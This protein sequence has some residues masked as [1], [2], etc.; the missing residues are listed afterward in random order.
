MATELFANNAV[1]ELFEPI[2][3]GDTTLR[4]VPG[5][6]SLFPTISGGS[7]DTFKL[8]IEVGSTREI[9]KVTATSGDT[10]TIAR[11][12]EGTSA[13]GWSASATIALRLTAAQI[14]AF[15]PF[16]L[17]G[18]VAGALPASNGGTGIASYTIGD[19]IVATAATVLGVISVGAT[20][21]LLQSNGTTPSYTA[22]PIITTLQALTALKI[23]ST[24]ASD[25]GV[26]L[27]NAQAIKARNNADSADLI[28]METDASDRKFLGGASDTIALKNETKISAL[29]ATGAALIDLFKL[30]LDDLFKILVDPVLSNNIVLSSRDVADTVT[31]PVAKV[32]TNDDIIFGDG[33]N[34]NIGIGRSNPE[35]RTHFG[36][37]VGY[38]IRT[39]TSNATFG[40]DF[41]ILADTDTSSANITLN[42]PPASLSL[43]RIYVAKKLSIAATHS[44]TIQ[45]AGAELI[46]TA[47]NLA[48][49]AP[50]ITKV[51]QC[52][53]TGWR[54]IVA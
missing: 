2:T 21:T 28:L 12:Q 7:G 1:S 27:S 15:Y 35:A 37:S 13:T 16:D 29:N 42:L 9:V 48:I 44:V 3:A 4:V 14:Q 30:S 26:R 49:S 41:T 45:P 11:G 25:G 47:S 54:L 34:R 18:G 43:G 40:D 10:F 6:E 20:N 36:G 32:D 17:T 38:P 8:T 19:L 52:D 5:D 53:G 24:P 39:V 22:N 23:G 50:N 33:L 31:I 51:M 46:E